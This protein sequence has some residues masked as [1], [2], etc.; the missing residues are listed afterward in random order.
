MLKVK[1]I[2]PRTSK[3]YCH[4]TDAWPNLE[5]SMWSSAYR[6][7]PVPT[8]RASGRQLNVVVD[9]RERY[10][11][12]FTEQQATIVKQTLRVGDYAVEQAGQMVAVVERKSLRIWCRRSSV[13][14]CGCSWPA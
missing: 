6:C 4:P 14:S 8:A 2:W 10:A 11:W 1:D 12:K 7:A 5:E 13:A 3:I 9:T